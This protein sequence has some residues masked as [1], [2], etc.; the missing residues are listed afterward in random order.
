MQCIWKT[1]ERT[2]CW[3][4]M[5]AKQ[6]CQLRNTMRA[7]RATFQL[8]LLSKLEAAQKSSVLPPEPVLRRPG[9]R[10]PVPGCHPHCP[11][12]LRLIPMAVRRCKSHGSFVSRR[13]PVEAR[14]ASYV[15][16]LL[17]VAAPENL[18]L[19]SEAPVAVTSPRLVALPHVRERLGKG[20]FGRFPQHT[21]T[22]LSC[23]SF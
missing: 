1:H 17:R 12:R 21:A 6:I 13:E 5:K 14:N 11:G 15:D 4:S 9:V 20:M 3:F 7:A 18:G 8:T 19:R 16:V 22:G 2:C 10:L 23:V